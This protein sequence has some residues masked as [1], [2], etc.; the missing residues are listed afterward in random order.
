MRRRARGFTLVEILVALA[1]LTIALSAMIRETAHAIGV[2]SALR[3]RTVALWIVQDIVATH[4][5]RA[6]WPRSGKASGT[7]EMAGRTWEW[8]EA[9]AGTAD[10]RFQRVDV[11]VGF[12]GEPAKLASITAYHGVP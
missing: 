2:S 5:I 6:D 4:R 9:V 8:R 10:R 7:R 3:D 12:P 11:S 1:I